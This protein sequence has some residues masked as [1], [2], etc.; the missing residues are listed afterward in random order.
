MQ[1]KVIL[2]LEK[3]QGVFIRAE[4]FIRINMVLYISDLGQGH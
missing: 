2:I 1:V 3:R 4:V